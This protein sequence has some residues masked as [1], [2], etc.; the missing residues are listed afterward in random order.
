MMQPPNFLTFNE[1]NYTV[2]PLEF[3]MFGSK[4]QGFLETQVALETNEW[5]ENSKKRTVH[6]LLH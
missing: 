1:Y 2:R 3:P 6:T 4:T 5:I